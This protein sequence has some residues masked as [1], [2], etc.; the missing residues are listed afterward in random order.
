MDSNADQAAAAAE[1]ALYNSMCVIVYLPADT[2]GVLLV[3]QS[4]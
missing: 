2:I 3:G 4:T 1:V